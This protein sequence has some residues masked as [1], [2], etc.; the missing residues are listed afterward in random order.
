M[1]RL[2][3]A[4]EAALEADVLADS[5]ARSIEATLGDPEAIAGALVLATEAAGVLGE[6]VGQRLASRWPAAELVGTSFEGIV[7]DGRV[8]EGPAVA[9]LA[10]SEGEG[11]PAVIACEGGAAPSELARAIEEGIARGRRAARHARAAAR[12]ARYPGLAVC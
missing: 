3:I 11:A 1:T 5:L 12:R 6:E 8:W 7:L 2:G 9:A 4:L 10:W